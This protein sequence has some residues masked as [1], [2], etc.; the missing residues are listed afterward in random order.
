MPT[1]V[2]LRYNPSTNTF[3]AEEKTFLDRPGFVNDF[4]A[5]PTILG[6]WD[7]SRMVLLG[8]TETGKHPVVPEPFLPT[9]G[10]HGGEI[11]ASTLLFVRLG[12]AFEA[13]DFSLA[14]YRSLLRR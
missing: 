13:L 1:C 10:R 6:G 7:D 5:D 12:E 9:H 3:V 11:R 14:D 4:V 2:I 8:P